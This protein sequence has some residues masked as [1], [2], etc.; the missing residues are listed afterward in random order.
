MNN[1][2]EVALQAAEQHS[3]MYWVCSA[4]VL[5]LFEE[6]LVVFATITYLFCYLLRKQKQTVEVEADPFSPQ[7]TDSEKPMLI[8]RTYEE[9]LTT[10]RCMYQ[11]FSKLCEA[12]A[13]GQLSA[14]A[15]TSLAALND[16]MANLVLSV[17]VLPE[18]QPLSEEGVL[19]I[20]K[21]TSI[22][23]DMSS[24][25][26][27]GFFSLSQ[28]LDMLTLRFTLFPRA[29]STVEVLQYY[30]PSMV[31][32]DDIPNQI[33]DDDA[34]IHHLDFRSSAGGR[35]ESPNDIQPSRHS[36][37]S[38][39]YEGG[40]FD[41]TGMS[42]ALW[43]E[44]TNLVAVSVDDADDKA[45]SR[46]EEVVASITNAAG[47]DLNIGTQMNV[48]PFSLPGRTAVALH[49]E[50]G[51][52][53]VFGSGGEVPPSARLDLTLDSVVSPVKSHVRLGSPLPIS[54]QEGGSNMLDNL[55]AVGHT[56]LHAG[57]FTDTADT[58]EYHASGET[59]RHPRA[60]T[61][62]DGNSLPFT[63]HHDSSAGSFVQARD[64]LPQS[65]GKWNDCTIRALDGCIAEFKRS[66]HDLNIC[67]LDLLQEVGRG[68]FAT[69]YQAR[70]SISTLSPPSLLRL[71]PAS[72]LDGKRDVAV[73]VLNLNNLNISEKT[74]LGFQKEVAVMR[75]PHLQHPNIV[76]FIGTCSDPVC[77]VTEF[78][79]G[80]NL[81]DLLAN[82]SI[83][84]DDN[85]RAHNDSSILTKSP[86]SGD[87]DTQ[88]VLNNVS[89]LRLS[90]ATDAACGMNIL[91][92]SRPTIIHRDLKSLN[93]LVDSTW[94]LK[95]ADFG[96]SRFKTGSQELLTGQCGTYHWMAPEVMSG[97]QYTEKADVYSFGINLWEIYTRKV[98]FSGMQPV[99]VVTSVYNKGQRPLVPGSCPFNYRSLMESC[100]HQDPEKR[101]GFPHIYDTL[102]RMKADCAQVLE[103]WD[104]V[105]HIETNLTSLSQGIGNGSPEFKD[106]TCVSALDAQTNMP[107]VGRGLYA[108]T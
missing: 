43:S 103:M 83:D 100:W 36:S 63:H 49:L 19:G 59:G 12:A 51:A 5:P 35:A 4:C 44:T 2:F 34:G 13:R 76:L 82:K 98:P 81:F 57:T 8:Y 74:I 40:S 108:S 11:K 22:E 86:S 32:L 93:L 31:D 17:F 47:D 41:F 88:S 89:L 18:H 101:P 37:Q 38:V 53:P 52:E 84:F 79:H 21:M 75:M 67:D 91:H 105:P 87:S 46:Q 72:D 6:S 42:P 62:K 28:S 97:E 68:A 33:M 50:I 78:C 26:G 16:S 7:G 27:E 107:A 15:S 69:V 9:Q 94:V 45:D 10:L 102:N 24:H 23:L 1:T 61:D 30:Y 104:K 58:F 65:L 90:L 3:E 71:N 70:M 80:G 14:A 77:I 85:I 99:Q 66:R 73:K 54:H 20:M 39:D 60:P 96:L 64:P 55:D 106:G 29:Q 95:I 48:D 56:D 92:S 25:F